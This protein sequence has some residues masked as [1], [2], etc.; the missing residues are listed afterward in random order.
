MHCAVAT[1][2]HPRPCVPEDPRPGLQ[3]SVE[4][5]PGFHWEVPHPGNPHARHSRT[6]DPTTDANIIISTALRER[7]RSLCVCTK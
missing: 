3:G 6:V 2:W 7:E 1:D 5:G 4:G